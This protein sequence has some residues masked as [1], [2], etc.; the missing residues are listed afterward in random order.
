MHRS[1]D[2]DMS[3]KGN[4]MGLTF[5]QIVGRTVVTAVLIVA[6]LGASIGGCAGYKSFH[7]AQAR[8]DAHNLARTER[9]KVEAVEARAEQ[10]YQESVGIKRAQDEIN[11]TLTP[12]YVQHE[13]I[14][15]LERSGAATVY[16]PSG[17]QGVP[18]VRDTSED[19]VTGDK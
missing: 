7:R 17:N 6:L 19:H 14:Q 5:G 10:R 8:A 1:Y 18:L 2:N 9:L 12:L 11:K 4:N 15:A 13:A 3:R 16:I